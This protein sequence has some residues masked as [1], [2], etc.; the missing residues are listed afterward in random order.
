MHLIQV[1]SMV[2]RRYGREAYRIFKHLSK[3]GRFL[4]TDWI[5]DKTFVEKKDAIMILYKLWKDDYVQMEKSSTGGVRPSVLLQ[6]KISRMLQE[7]FL[8]ELYHAALNLRLRIAHEKDQ[9]KEVLQLP[10]EKLVGE[11]KRRYELAQKV[12]IVL[13]S[14]LIN[15]DDAIMLF[16]NF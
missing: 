12:R 3:A 4:E 15:L 14:S 11:L 1:E 16:Q 6:C 13:E 10:K 7:K 5:A 9:A 2:L 8:D